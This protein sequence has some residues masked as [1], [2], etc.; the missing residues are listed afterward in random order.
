MGSQKTVVIWPCGGGSF[1]CCDCS[2]KWAVYIHIPGYTRSEENYPEDPG[3]LCP[4]S[5]LQDPEYDSGR[6]YPAKRRK[7][8]I[9]LVRPDRY[10]DI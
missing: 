8:E 6:R 7:N 10:M 5:A 3:C 9:S 2:D 1:I 4:Y